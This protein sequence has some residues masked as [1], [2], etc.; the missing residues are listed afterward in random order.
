MYTP[1]VLNSLAAAEKR[2]LSVA[3]VLKKKKKSP[4]TSNQH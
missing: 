1:Q 2:N 4:L 3:A